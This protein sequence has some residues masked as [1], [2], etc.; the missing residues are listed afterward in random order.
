MLP[1]SEKTTQTMDITTQIDN[2]KLNHFNDFLLRQIQLINDNKIRSLYRG[3][4]LKN[5][6][7]KLGVN[8]D[9]RES[10]LIELF[11][12]LF[13]IGE[14]SKK[15]YADEFWGYDSNSRFKIEDCSEDVFG[16][17][18][19]QID[20][21]LKNKNNKL[22]KFLDKNTKFKN[23]F[24]DKENKNK[25]IA[26]AIL[27]PE[28]LRKYFKSYYL[29]LLH[30]LG[31]VN[32]KNKSDLVS[33]TSNYSIAQVFSKANQINDPI[34]I[35]F[36][37]PN[38]SK[39]AKDFKK[40][41]MP[42]YVGLP[43]TEQKETSLLAGIL[44]HFIIGIEIPADETLYLNPNIFTNEINDDLFLQGMIINQTNFISIWKKTNYKGYYTSNYKGIIE[45]IKNASR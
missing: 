4:N 38:S 20:K 45:N 24:H 25:F 19:F 6:Q 9:N 27:I 10:D 37:I 39:L 41:K 18:F 21:A 15:F 34:I 8:S 28:N 1:A 7:D 29:T 16:H 32:Y 3:D 22:R 35:H 44:P 23:Y 43:Y 2:I 42:K 13:M 31:Y 40:Y 12:R 30:Q 26:S 17:I 11:D 14:K 36:W 5:L 33:A